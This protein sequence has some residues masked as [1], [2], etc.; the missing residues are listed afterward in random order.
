MKEPFQDLCRIMVSQN[1][2][3]QY[4]KNEIE[5]AAYSVEKKERRENK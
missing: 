1:N 3:L 4:A 2:I 5:N